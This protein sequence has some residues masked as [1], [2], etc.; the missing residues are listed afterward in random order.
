MKRAL[1][2]I[3]PKW[4]AEDFSKREE[5]GIL[6]MPDKAGEILHLFDADCVVTYGMSEKCSV[7]LSSIAEND[8]VI[9]LQRELPTLDGELLERQ[10]LKMRRPDY[11]SEESLLATASVLLISG[12]DP[13]KLSNFF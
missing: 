1:I 6:L 4:K 2:T 9:S 8:A 3:P 10:E 7:T 5:C 11:V 12:L 13:E